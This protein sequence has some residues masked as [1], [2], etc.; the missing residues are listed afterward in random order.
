MTLAHVDHVRVVVLARD[1]RVAASVQTALG[2]APIEK[3]RWNPADPA[4]PGSP[5]VDPDLL[6][7]QADGV[8]VAGLLRAGQD[9][10]WL[11][12]RVP[13]VV[14]APRPVERI[15]RLTWLQAGAWQ[16]ARLPLDPEVFQL[17]IRNLLRGYPAAIW[18]HAED[19]AYART[20]LLRV[21]EENLALAQRHGRPLSAAAFCLDWGSRRADEDALAVMRRL[22]IPAHEAVRGSDLVGVTAQG[23]LVV[24]LPD[25]DAAGA[26]IF[27]TRLTP[28]LEA[29]LRGW[30][31]VGRIISAQISAKLDP[32]TP[33][34]MFLALADQA[35]A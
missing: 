33:A 35:V 5:P 12:I 13:V 32:P 20:A 19:E 31:F 28:L 15:V 7:V 34:E 21:T 24:L 29:R 14:L 6:I 4:A 26:R 17:Q 30:G 8:D 16:I 23:T 11:G 9:E 10:G 18:V 25:T 2:E 1:E 3:V 22:S 27:T